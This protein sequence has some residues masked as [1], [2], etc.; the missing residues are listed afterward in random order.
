MGMACGNRLASSLLQESL[1]TV[2]S[3]EARRKDA[4]RVSLSSSLS[5]LRQSASGGLRRCRV[6]A[7]ALVRLVDLYSVIVCF[8]FT[9]ERDWIGCVE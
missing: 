3:S 5:Q 7:F 1:M 4:R 2:A 9:F 8:G 6:P